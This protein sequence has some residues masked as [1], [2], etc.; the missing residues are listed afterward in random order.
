MQKLHVAA[1]DPATGQARASAQLRVFTAWTFNLAALYA[2]DEVTPLPN[3]LIADSAG[4]AAFKV[5]DG[6]YDIEVSGQGFTPY[7]LTLVQAMDKDGYA[8]K[9][10]LENITLGGVT[11]QMLT[12]VDAKLEFGAVGNGSVDDWAAIQAAINSRRGPVYLRPGSYRISQ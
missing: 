5:A 9:T 12:Y 7:K 8:T 3:P 4:R 1:V 2:D 11:V 10:E 6:E